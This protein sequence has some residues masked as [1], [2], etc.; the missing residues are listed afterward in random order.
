MVLTQEKV[1]LLGVIEEHEIKYYSTYKQM[2]WE[3]RNILKY[4]KINPYE[5]SKK[6]YFKYITKNN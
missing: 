1:F 6:I 5:H 2:V 3:T 4:K